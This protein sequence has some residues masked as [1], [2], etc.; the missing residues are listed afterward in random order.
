MNKTVTEAELKAIREAKPYAEAVRLTA[1][2]MKRC[3]FL[4]DLEADAPLYPVSLETAADALTALIHDRIIVPAELDGKQFAQLLSYLAE[5]IT[6]DFHIE[7]HNQIHEWLA[8][9]QE[10]A[11]SAAP[12]IPPHLYREDQHLESDF[13]DRVSGMGEY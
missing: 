4:G 9:R 12:Q 7:A 8:I 2:L 3:D 1:T 6:C 5:S 11:A 10:L 13:E